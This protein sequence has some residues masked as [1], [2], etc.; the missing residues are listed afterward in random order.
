M[1]KAVLISIKPKWVAMILNGKKT[2]LVSKTAPKLET[3]FKEYIY[4]TKEGKGNDLRLHVNDMKGRKDVGV[5]T[6]WR[7]RKNVL[8]EH[9]SKYRF[10]S[11]LAEG[12]VVAVL[13]AIFGQLFDKE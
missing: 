4:C 2:I 5:T 1:S 8:N 13:E 6:W 7:D 3:P 11:Y 9:L 10:N 12:K